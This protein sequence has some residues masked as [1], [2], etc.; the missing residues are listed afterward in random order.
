MKKHILGLFLI[1]LLATTSPLAAITISSVA[2]VVNADIITSY[3]LERAVAMLL[4]RQNPSRA[5]SDQELQ[6]L[7]QEVLD[8]LINDR[9]LHQRSKELGLRVSDQEVNAAIDDVMISNNLDPA[10]LE[11]ALAAEGMTLES[12]RQQIR[13]EILRYKL[14]SQEVNYR[15]QVTSSEVRRYFE[16]HIDQFDTQTRLF[17]SRISFVLPADRSS[18]DNAR[19]EEQANKSRQ[20]LLGGTPF[21]TV[22]AEA[23]DS[24]DGGIMGELV[25]TDLAPPLQ[26]ALQH[27]QAGEVSVP[28]ELNQQLHLFIINDRRSGEELAFERARRSIEERL[29][30]EK[31][32]VRF[33]EWEKELR[34]NA[35]IDRRL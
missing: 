5:P 34:S 22:L 27:L 35:Y 20:Q 2:A 14:M 23:G 16:E 28:T 3:Q 29:R 21:D 12:Y 24:A 7:R 33:I 15:A 26:Q 19:I 30:R 25:L 32:E 6:D 11:I 10:S 13:D 1:L 17:V 31:T 4:S 8:Q 9:L 18:A